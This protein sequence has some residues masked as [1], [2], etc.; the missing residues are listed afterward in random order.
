MTLKLKSTTNELWKGW[1][2][3]WYHSICTIQSHILKLYKLAYLGYSLEK[4]VMTVKPITSQSG[5]LGYKTFS[6]RV[7]LCAV[8]ISTFFHMLCGSNDDTMPTFNLF[9]VHLKCFSISGSYSWKKLVNAWKITNEV[10][11]GWKL[12]MWLWMVHFEHTKSLEFK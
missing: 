2:L 9:R 4:K 10:R 5:I 12:M 3:A 8:T 11:K 1:N 7:S 6:S